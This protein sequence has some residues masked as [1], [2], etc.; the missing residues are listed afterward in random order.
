RVPEPTDAAPALPPLDESDVALRG[1]LQALVGRAPFESFFVPMQI[2]RRWV[3]FIDSLDRDGVPLARR[4][5]KSVAGR[6]VVET[7][8]G[9]LVLGVANAQRY[10]AYL[11]VLQAVDAQALVTFYFRDYPLFQQAYDE[12]GY[13]GRYFNTRL[14]DVIDHLLAT[15]DVPGPIALVQPKVLYQ[16]AD[17]E[18]ESLSFGQKVLIRSGAD[19]A[20]AVKARLREIRAA[21]VA[22]TQPAAAP[23]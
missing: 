9:R 7:V 13:G 22:R 21:I 12:L 2:V 20:V 1:E 19:N 5:A 17:P 3:G 14:L 16:F 8:D 4:P 15:P 10:S 6:P 11:A 23:G 18:L